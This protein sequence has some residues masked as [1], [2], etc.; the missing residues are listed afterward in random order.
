MQNIWVTDGFQAVLGLD[1]FLSS[2]ADVLCGFVALLP[3][4]VP[5]H[6][7]RWSEGILRH[8]EAGGHRQ[9]GHLPAWGVMQDR[10][11]RPDRVYH[12]AL[13]PG[14]CARC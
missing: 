13:T 1:V 7:F 8:R 2:C 5:D 6:F 12:F 14:T 9:H 4:Q 11:R 10:I 3:L